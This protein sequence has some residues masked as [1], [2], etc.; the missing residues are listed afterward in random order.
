MG[1]FESVV[2]EGEMVG[3]LENGRILGIIE[4]MIRKSRVYT[5]EIRDFC[6]VW[7]WSHLENENY[8]KDG[9]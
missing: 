1:D 2:I 9:R 5:D 3:I 8:W 4:G 6:M 7:N